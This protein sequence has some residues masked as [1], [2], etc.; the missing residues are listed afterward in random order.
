MAVAQA[1]AENVLLHVIFSFAS[2]ILLGIAGG[3]VLSRDKDLRLNQMFLGFF[4][5]IGGHQIL[6]GLMTYF[7]FGPKDIGIADLVRDFS[8]IFLII[9]LSFGALVALNLYYGSNLFVTNNLIIWG[10]ITSLLL[11]G[12]VIGDSVIL[13]GYYGDQPSK[14]RDIFGWIG[15]T[16]SIFL[17]SIIIIVF[18][19]LLIRNVVDS[20]VQQKVM[21]ITIGFFLINLIVF[22]FDISFVFPLFR[23]IIAIPFFHFCV[24]LIA[25]VGGFIT[26]VVLWT[27]IQS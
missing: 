13:G 6:D 12:G 26:V 11:I 24:H 3:V 23:D 27:P 15:I 7:L 1:L 16:G 20:K 22:S 8:I 25:L 21:G 14:I 4:V 18:L 5:G 19:S 9:G 2:G 17:Y 10:G